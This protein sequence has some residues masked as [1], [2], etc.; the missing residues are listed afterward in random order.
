MKSDW[1]TRRRIKARLHTL[2][3]AFG[4]VFSLLESSAAYA[5]KSLL[6]EDR[7]IE[8]QPEDNGGENNG[9]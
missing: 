7:L 5:D 8:D 9:Q 6:A 2:S 4:P 3:E 1:N